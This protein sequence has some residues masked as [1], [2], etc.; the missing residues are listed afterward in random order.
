MAN[1]NKTYFPRNKTIHYE[2]YL[3]K[4]FFLWGINTFSTR[5]D[6]LIITSRHDTPPR[7]CT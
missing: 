3:F 4:S 2:E 1:F 6:E 7:D 5:V